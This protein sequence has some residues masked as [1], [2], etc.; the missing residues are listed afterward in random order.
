M[1]WFPCL[2]LITLFWSTWGLL[3]A[4]SRPPLIFTFTTTPSRIQLV[5]GVIRRLLDQ[6]VRPDWVVVNIPHFSQR[7]Q[8]P[9][10]LPDTL[11]KWSSHPR[12]RIQRCEDEG[13]LTKLLPTLEWWNGDPQAMLI[14]VDDDV[15]HTPR[16]F[17]ELVANSL[18]HPEVV[19]GYHGVQIIQGRWVFRCAVKTDVDMVETVAGAVYRRHMLGKPDE[20]RTLMQTHAS[21]WRTDDVVIN[22]QVARKGFRRTLIPSFDIVGAQYAYL[23]HPRY[24]GHI[25]ADAVNPLFVDNQNQHHNTNCMQAL[26]QT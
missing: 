24:P 22:A 2:L 21:C 17:E 23:G 4:P 12:V 11:Q 26:F 5:D 13:P 16:F 25:H 7:E 14:P 18:H 8:K 19:V 1:A 15:V 20:L 3:V 10:E 9:Y 6:T